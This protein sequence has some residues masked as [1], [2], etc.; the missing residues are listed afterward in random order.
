[1]HALKKPIRRNLVSHSPL[2]SLRV[3]C[4]TDRG[5]LKTDPDVIQEAGGFF[6]AGSAR[7]FPGDE[8]SKLG[9]GEPKRMLDQ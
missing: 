6:S 5:K 8:L 9:S 1:M 7:N 3:N 2:L 4:C